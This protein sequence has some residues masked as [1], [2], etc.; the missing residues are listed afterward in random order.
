MDDHVV[1]VG[2]TEVVTGR[3]CR[4]TSLAHETGKT[5]SGHE[6]HFWWNFHA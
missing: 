3:I 1:Y 5:F 4:G 6:T 2:G